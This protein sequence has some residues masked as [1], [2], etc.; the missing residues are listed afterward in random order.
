M[1][2]RLQGGEGLSGG[3]IGLECQGEPGLPSMANYSAIFARFEP[4]TNP[5]MARGLRDDNCPQAPAAHRTEKLVVGDEVRGEFRN[6]IRND[7]G[8]TGRSGPGPDDVS[9]GRALGL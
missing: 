9:Q 6:D 7:T 8:G 1:S 2:R 5:M 3:A 4:P